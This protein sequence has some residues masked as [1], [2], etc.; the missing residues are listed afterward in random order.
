MLENTGLDKIDFS[1]NADDLYREETISDLKTAI[2][3]RFVPVKLDG[4]DDPERP[5]RY[6]AQTQLMSPHGPLPIQ[7]DLEVDNLKEAI[8]KFP[9]AMK[10]ALEEMVENAKRVQQQQNLMGGGDSRIIV[11]GR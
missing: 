2:I 1:V 11:P 3:K 7:A 8:E 4:T 6:L 5:D 9:T 10:T